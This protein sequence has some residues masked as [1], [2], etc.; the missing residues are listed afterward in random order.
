MTESS[1]NLGP[2]LKRIHVNQNKLRA[3]VKDPTRTDHCYTIKFKGKTYTAYQV[4]IDGESRLV[5]SI[6]KPLSCGAR[7]WL[8]TT[9]PIRMEI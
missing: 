9:A 8:E 6:E 7:L 2:G 3:R 4:F 5:E 1:T